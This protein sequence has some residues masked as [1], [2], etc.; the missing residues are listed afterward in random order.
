MLSGAPENKARRARPEQALHRAAAQFLDVALPD[1]AV[2]FHPP[3]G[4]AR[5]KAEAG[6]FRALGVKAGVPDLVIVYRGR[7]IA[8]ELKAPR[9]RLTAAQRAMHKRLILAAPWWAPARPWIP[10]PAS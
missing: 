10:W 3:N 7:L 6:I 4:G 5:T 1:D 9:G 2:W 8:I